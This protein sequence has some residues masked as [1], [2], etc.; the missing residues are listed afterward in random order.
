MRYQLVMNDE[1]LGCGHTIHCGTKVIEFDAPDDEAAQ[2]RV[3]QELEDHDMDRI[4]A[5][6][7]YRIP[8]ESVVPFNLEA[9][10]EEV[11]QAKAAAKV[12]QQEAK[13]RAEYERLKRKFQQG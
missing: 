1:D 2:A 9:V 6:D 12:A 10:Q 7:L 8:P 3:R 5:V 4:A 13:E 11:A